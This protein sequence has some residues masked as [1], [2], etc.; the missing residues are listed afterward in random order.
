LP[1]L[2][3]PSYLHRHVVP[4]LSS[5]GSK[6][7]TLARRSVSDADADPHCVPHQLSTDRVSREDRTRTEKARGVLAG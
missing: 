2:R 7:G 5:L 6:G 3:L 1:A 4:L